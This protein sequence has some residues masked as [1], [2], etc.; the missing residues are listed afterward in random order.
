MVT[1]H[2]PQLARAADAAP[3]RTLIQILRET[4]ERFPDSSALDDGRTSLSYAE[5]LR[6]VK[7]YGR[8]LHEAGIGAGDKVGVRIP[9]GTNELYVAILAILYVGAAYVPVDADDPD[10]RARLVFE[11]AGVAGITRAGEIITSLAR[12]RPFPAARQATPKD[13]AWVIFTSGST[14]TPK[15]VAVTHCSAAAFVDAEARLFLPTEPVNPS[16]RVL[17]GLSVAFDASCEEM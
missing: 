10:E 6:D 7:A 9:S 15:G 8:R 4:A 5:L 11:E 14:G 1:A 16:D 12:V 3:S 13:D 17:A 2:R